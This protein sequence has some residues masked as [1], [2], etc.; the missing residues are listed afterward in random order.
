MASI[1]FSADPGISAVAG[2]SAVVGNVVAVAFGSC[3]KGCGLSEE[4]EDE[5]GEEYKASVGCLSILG[6]IVIMGGARVE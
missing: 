4:P 1:T 2:I 5:A 3:E 6:V